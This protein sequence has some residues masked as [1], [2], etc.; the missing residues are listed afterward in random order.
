MK[1]TYQKPD[2]EFVRFLAEEAIMDL[3]IDGSTGV[4]TGDENWE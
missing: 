2:A 4:G 3:I 1:K